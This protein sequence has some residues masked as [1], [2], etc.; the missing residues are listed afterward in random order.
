MQQLRSTYSTMVAGNRTRTAVMLMIWMRDA[1]ALRTAG[2]LR[3]DQAALLGSELG[4]ML[5]RVGY[6]RSKRVERAKR[7]PSLPSCEPAGTEDATLAHSAAR[8]HASQGLLTII[9]KRVVKRIRKTIRRAAERALTYDVYFGEWHPLR[10]R[11]R[12]RVV[13]QGQAAGA[14]AAGP[15]GERM[16]G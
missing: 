10:G 15:A 4:G 9:V 8:A 6:G 14:R 1:E 5:E 11:L 12:L 3:D 16:A 2:L 7:W 13:R